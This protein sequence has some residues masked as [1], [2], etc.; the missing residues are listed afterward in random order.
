[1]VGM[2][3]NPAN[4]PSRYQSYR[5]YGFVKTASTP[6]REGDPITYTLFDADGA[7]FSFDNYYLAMSTY[8]RIMSSHF[9]EFYWRRPVV[10][11][12]GRAA[13]P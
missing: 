10:T 5:K 6:R 1:F 4:D 9:R 11:P 12:E 13:M 8:E 7:A 2:N 3:D